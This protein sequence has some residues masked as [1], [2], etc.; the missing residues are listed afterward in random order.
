MTRWGV[1]GIRAQAG[2]AVD[3]ARAG[4]NLLGLGLVGLGAPAGWIASR[5]SGRWGWFWPRMGLYRG[6]EL[7]P[8]EARVWLQAVSVGE[9][10][11]AWA[12]A[13]RLVEAGVEVVMTSSTQ[14]GLERARALAGAQALVLPMP[15]DVPW[16]VAAAV[17]AIRPT[18]Y[19]SVETE[20]WPNLS[21]RLGAAGVVQV[22]VNGRISPRSF[23]RYSRLKALVGPV[24]GRL[25]SLGMISAADAQR[26]VALGAAPGR[27]E[28]VGNAKYALL[29]DRLARAE[30]SRLA[31]RLGVQA[32]AVVVAGSVRTGEIVP[33]LE[34]FKLL[35]QGGQEALLVVVPR[36][37]GR[38]W[39]W[40]EAARARG[41]GVV[42]WS[43]LA[44][45]GRRPREAKVVVV[46]RMGLLL[47][48][49]GLA[50]AAFVGASL[51][52]LGG[53]NPMEP[54]AWGVRVCFGPDMSDFADEARRL[55]QAG[56]AEVVR[57]AR[58]LADAW[59]R[60]IAMG[61]APPEAARQLV[62][63]S[64]RA[65]ARYAAMVLRAVV[66]GM[67]RAG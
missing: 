64:R 54:A 22:L 1:G 56:A 38:S 66:E 25:R 43:E 16:A 34:A 45:L 6:V 5:L 31:G 47:E 7:A 41:L 53:Q 27:V 9:V 63:A 3:L 61:P 4:Y 10:E 12:V 40:V 13:R 49:Y 32:E 59:A 44:A 36:H 55:L 52:E 62:A 65:A 19:G 50:D 21:A 30:P 35:L 20:L 11:V 14:R 2:T 18:A 60:A 39:R 15:V 67:K 33:V 8:G 58:E 51:V 26:V 17:R 42:R 46:D 24:L 29:A 48:L 23:P 37:E 57:D 28:V